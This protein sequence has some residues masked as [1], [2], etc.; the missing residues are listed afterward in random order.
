MLTR[1][2]IL[3]EILLQDFPGVRKN[4]TPN[5]DSLSWAGNP[6][7]T[8]L[9]GTWQNQRFSDQSMLEI[10]WLCAHHRSTFLGVVSVVHTNSTPVQFHVLA[11]IQI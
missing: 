5:V 7:P 9:L 11:T 6:R 1:I 8:C 4:S 2:K 10:C 3:F